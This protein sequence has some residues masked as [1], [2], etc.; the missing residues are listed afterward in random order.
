MY[1]RGKIPHTTRQLV[2]VAALTVLGRLNELK[3]HIKAAKL[4]QAD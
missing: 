2:T 3:L 4:G 1:A